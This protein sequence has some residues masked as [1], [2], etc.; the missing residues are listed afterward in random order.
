[1]TFDSEDHKIIITELLKRANFPGHLLDQAIEL[2]EAVANGAVV[3][4]SKP[5]PASKRAR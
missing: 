2:R 1:M 3:A 5:K 4:P